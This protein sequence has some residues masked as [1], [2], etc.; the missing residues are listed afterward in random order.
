MGIHWY[1]MEKKVQTMQDSKRSIVAWAFYDWA[2]SA[3]ATT[4]MAGFFPVFFSAYWA[5]GASSQE[6]T[7]YLGLANSMGSLIVAL[8]API[9]GAIA[10][11]GGTYKK[12]LLAFFLH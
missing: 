2:N 5:V 7:F 6:G 10:D 1:A 9:L 8:L 3:F 11:W 12:R 4:V